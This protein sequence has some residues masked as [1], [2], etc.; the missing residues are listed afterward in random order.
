M[1]RQPRHE[2]A[3][4]LAFYVPDRTSERTSSDGVTL[5]GNSITR[6]SWYTLVPSAGAKNSALCVSW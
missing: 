3:C 2:N 1:L 5:L 6:G 4:P